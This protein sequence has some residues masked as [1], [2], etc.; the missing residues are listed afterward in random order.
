MKAR[1]DFRLLK[2]SDRKRNIAGYGCFNACI[3]QLFDM[4]QTGAAGSALG[5]SCMT[6]GPARLP[7]EAVNSG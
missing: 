6:C 5:A 7:R 1:E 2:T 3:A 4:D